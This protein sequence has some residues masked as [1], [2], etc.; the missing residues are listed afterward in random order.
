MQQS[1]TLTTSDVPFNNYK[2][3]EN[4][5]NAALL[6]HPVISLA[7]QSREQ[8]FWPSTDWIT[9]PFFF[10]FKKLEPGPSVDLPQQRNML[11]KLKSW[12]E[13]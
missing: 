12:P 4:C 10:F 8:I 11:R 1:F 9:P 6:P 3:H 5:S 7:M 2:L 13:S